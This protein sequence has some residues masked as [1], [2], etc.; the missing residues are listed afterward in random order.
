MRCSLLSKSEIRPPDGMAA[1]LC[2]VRDIGATNR[3]AAC[4]NDVSAGR[5]SSRGSRTILQSVTQ[6]PLSFGFGH[7]V[8]FGSR[9][10]SHFFGY[11]LVPASGLQIAGRARSEFQALEKKVRALVAA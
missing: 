6:M 11:W 7:I 1:T 2:R 3:P 8:A 10:R 5:I 4:R 9:T